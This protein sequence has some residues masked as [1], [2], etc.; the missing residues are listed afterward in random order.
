[1][2]T[3]RN[4]AACRLVALAFASVLGLGLGGCSGS[5]GGGAQPGPGGSTIVLVALVGPVA[6]VLRLGRARIAAV[7]TL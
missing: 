1:M 4:G 7:R 2:T 5:S 3:T 6:L